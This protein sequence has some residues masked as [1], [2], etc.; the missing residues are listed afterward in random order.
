MAVESDHSKKLIF[1]TQPARNPARGV[2]IKKI[3]DI[4]GALVSKLV[5]TQFRHH[6]TAVIAGLWSINHNLMEDLCNSGKFGW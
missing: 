2:I 1:R 3:S 4:S 6:N 5:G